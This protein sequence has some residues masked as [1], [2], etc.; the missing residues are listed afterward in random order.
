MHLE[1]L[2]GKASRKWYLQSSVNH[3]ALVKASWLQ[4][5][6]EA[7]RFSSLRSNERKLFYPFKTITETR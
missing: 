6:D 5:L 4:N 7:L 3:P 1:M 2:A